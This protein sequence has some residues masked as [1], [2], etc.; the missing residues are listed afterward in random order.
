MADEVLSSSLELDIS[1]ALSAI[2][3]LGSELDSGLSASADTFTSVMAD[4]VSSVPPADVEIDPVGADAITTDIDSAVTAADTTAQIDAVGADV[5]TSDIDAAVGAADTNIAVE[6]DT[7]DALAAISALDPAPLDIPVEADTTDAQAALDGLDSSAS[8]AAPALDNAA[9][10]G[11]HLSRASDA[12][13]ASTGL[14]VGSTSEFKGLVGGLSPELGAATLGAGALAGGIFEIYSKGVQ[15]VS[16]TQRF[17]LIVGDMKDKV[18]SVHVGTLNTDLTTLGAKMGDTRYQTETAAATVFQFAA[19]AGASGTAAAGFADNVYALAARAVAL[20]PALGS[21]SDVATRM[22]IGLGRAR[23]AA[24]QF[25]IS[26]SQADINSRAMH[27][28]NTANA[29][30]LTTYEKSVAGVE[31]ALE[32]Y[33]GTLS[34]TVAAGE[35]NA[36]IQQRRLTAEFDQ[37]LEDL[38]TPIVSPGLDLIASAIPVG[39]AF[40]QVLGDVATSVL[41]AVSAGL[42]LIG[43]PLGLLADVLGALSPVITAGAAA[44]LIYEAATTVLPA[45]LGLL[46]N[47][48]LAVA[49]NAP[50]AG[51]A[52]LGAAGAVEAAEVGIEATLGP[53]GLLAAG[54]GVAFTAF[55][56]FGGGAD[57]GSQQVTDFGNA[58]EKASGKIDE[59][60]AKAAGAL[61]DERNQTDDLAGAG[62]KLADV[63]RA[64]TAAHEGQRSVLSDIANTTDLLT[65]AQENNRGATQDGK[66]AIEQLTAQRDRHIA[67]LQKEN[68]ALG[69]IVNMLLLEDSTNSGVVRTLTDLSAQHDKFAAAARRSAAAGTDQAHA[70]TAAAAA[71]TG[72]TVGLSA[73]EQAA[74]KAQAAHQAVATEVNNAAATF[75]N[76]ARTQYEYATGVG[77][78]AAAE[79][80]LKAATSELGA[81]LDRFLGRFVDADQAVNNYKLAVDKASGSLFANGFAFDQ[82][83]TAGQENRNTYD[84]LT[85]KAISASEAILTSTH[86]VT[87]AKQPLIDL[88]GNVAKLGFDMATAGNVAGAQFATDLLAHIDGAIAAVGTEAPKAKTGGAAVGHAIGDGSLTELPHSED[89][90]HQHGHHHAAAV[91]ETAPESGAGGQAHGLAAV[92]GSLTELDNIFGAGQQHGRRHAEGINTLAGA[93]LTEGANLGAQ[94]ALGSL[95]QLDNVTGAGA[96]LGAGSAQGAGSQAG[97]HLSTGAALGGFLASGVG[98][99]G[100]AVAGAAASVAAQG[101][102]AAGGR[103]GDYAAAGANSAGGLADGIRSVVGDVVAAAESVANSAVAGVRAAFHIAS[104]SRVMMDIGSDVGLGLA[105]GIEGTHARV[106][107]AFAGFGPGSLSPFAPSLGGARAGGYSSQ[108]FVFNIAVNGVSDPQVARRVG[109]E[110]GAGAVD[111]LVRRRIVMASRTGG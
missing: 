95:S 74:V 88:R 12:I 37:F 82:N 48:L 93:S 2:E 56:L 53:I 70:S 4:A 7:T 5:I 100:G 43:P 25:G 20:N 27:D 55:G 92:A 81:E 52:V 59:A 47:G 97:A 42:Q 49:V 51:E 84:D 104:P 99:V 41:P 106:N 33:G 62:I 66:V 21:V 85:K 19:N 16:A 54:L 23:T 11:E 26:I 36:A 79:D 60:G 73:S 17:N 94:T 28:T 68:P 24:Q 34:S 67:A 10:G 1:A 65:S 77:T 9:A 3:Q 78:A 90:G 64:T 111:A 13:A 75:T 14:A 31:I 102:G 38:G 8:D 108:A 69:Q 87:A 61:F 46:S 107:D 89:A 39:E 63:L 96:T 29:A 105:L 15:A 45:A 58:V 18:E 44:W 98:S 57:K 72:L 109:G 32:R 22:E 71:N 83:T 80:A 76:A 101:A 110:L 103:R 91:H 35:Q 86:N 30:S 40:G 50:V 6:A